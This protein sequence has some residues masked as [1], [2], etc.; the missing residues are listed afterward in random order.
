MAGA[1]WSPL[2]VFELEDILF[3]I[4]VVDG[5]P[6]TARRIGEEL[7]DFI[8]KHAIENRPGQK[9]P[10]AP[11]DWYYLKFKRWLVFYRPHPDGIE[12]MRVIDAVRDLPSL[13]RS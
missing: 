4:R 6:E 1:V 11:N 9:H 10:L 12:V 7:R 13:L 2:A 3:Y 8:D 5:R